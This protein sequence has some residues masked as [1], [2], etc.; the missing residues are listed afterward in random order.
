MSGGS[1][2]LMRS[3]GPDAGSGFWPISPFSSTTLTFHFAE[4]QPLNIH[5]AVLK[6][7]PA[8]DRLASLKRMLL[9][10]FPAMAGHSL[11]HYLYT[12]Q[13]DP[14]VWTGPPDAK[15]LIQ[16][17]QAK[18]HM[19][20]L[21]RTLELDALET[22][23]REDIQEF[24]GGLDIFA[25]MDAVKRG[26]PVP[27]RNDPWFHDW[28]KGRIKAAFAQPK[29][30]VELTQ[31]QNPDDDMG[32]AKVILVCMLETFADTMEALANSKNGDTESEVDGIT[33]FDMVSSASPHDG[34]V[35][36]DQDTSTTEPFELLNTP[37]ES[38]SASSPPASDHEHNAEWEFYDTQHILHPLQ[39][40]TPAPQPEE[41]FPEAEVI[42]YSERR[43]RPLGLEVLFGESGHLEHTRY[44]LSPSENYRSTTP[45]GLLPLLLDAHPEP[46]PP[47]GL[48]PIPS[49]EPDP[50][51]LTGLGPLGLGE[52]ELLSLP[53]LGLGG[54]PDFEPELVPEP[55]PEP[56]LE[57]EN[58]KLESG[59]PLGWS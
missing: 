42:P 51:M 59:V 9:T 20:S 56:G 13:Y 25:I 29:G 14:P 43:K 5:Q 39:E 45:I 49:P 31:P 53:E 30:L 3:N 34:G 11:F 4:D 7:C 28:I 17:L 1:T 8:L 10:D 24:A 35:D 21:A 2:N 33:G 6:R 40:P 46:L 47:R 41:L 16:Q 37:P 38:Q 22:L 12:G 52:P 15:G 19:Y 32:V 27:I 26:Y 55:E 18:F 57:L 23:V 58:K 44:D 54:S 48:E 50:L 36:E